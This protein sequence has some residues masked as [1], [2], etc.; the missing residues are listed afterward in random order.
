MATSDRMPAAAKCP[1]LTMCKFFKISI[2]FFF[3]GL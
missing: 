1:N 3:G 2:A